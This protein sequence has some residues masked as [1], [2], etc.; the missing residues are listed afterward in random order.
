MPNSRTE[1]VK[2]VFEKAFEV[3]GIP[4][5]IRSD[6]GT[7]FAASNSPFGLSRL[8]AWWLALGISLD[9]IDPGCPFK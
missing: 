3:Y 5:I 8:S 1:N 4:D 7:P 6:N 9:R 2:N